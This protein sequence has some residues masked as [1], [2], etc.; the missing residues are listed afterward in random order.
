MENQIDTV[1]ELDPEP[2]QEPVE[3][4]AAV[5]L[6]IEPRLIT[7]YQYG[8]NMQYIG[9]YEFHKNLN[10]EEIHM[11][12]NT[13][14]VPPLENTPEHKRLFWNGSEWEAL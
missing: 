2:A 10:V 8:D 7:A 11:P 5:V 9:S 1:E 6:E 14:L 12:P 13:T 3:P 4:F